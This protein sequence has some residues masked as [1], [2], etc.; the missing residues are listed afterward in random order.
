MGELEERVAFLEKR[1]RRINGG[2]RGDVME[3][4]VRSLERKKRGKEER[5]MREGI[6][7]K[8]FKEEKGD[9]KKGMEDVF[10]QIGI[11]VKVEEIRFV[12]T[13][14][15]ERKDGCSKIERRR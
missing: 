9:A 11:N 7:V 13:E 8:G 3:E 1:D 12:R 6:I 14:K 4:M 5:D 15:E 2:K 10:K